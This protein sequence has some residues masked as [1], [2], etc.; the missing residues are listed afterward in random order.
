MNNKIFIVTNRC[1][2]EIGGPILFH[3]LENAKKYIKSEIYDYWMDTIGETL[4]DELG[5]SAL[6]DVE[7]VFLY[8]MERGL[9]KKLLNPASKTSSES[10][11]Y[12]FNVGSNDWYE[13]KITRMVLPEDFKDSDPANY[14]PNESF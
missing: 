6:N 3:S 4:K 5:E 12:R 11:T 14:D 13:F 9:C 10:H 1:G 8:C 2:T 7:R